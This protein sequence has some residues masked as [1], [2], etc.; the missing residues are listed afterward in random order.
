MARDLRRYNTRHDAVLSILATSVKETLPPSTNLTV[1]IGGQYKFPCYIIPT[2]LRPD[3]VWWN[4]AEKSLNLMEL[5]VCFES[6][7]EDAAQ[8][9]LSKYTELTDL[10]QQNGYET[11]LLPVQ[12]GSRGVPD[13]PSFKALAEETGMSQK[14]LTVLIKN[15]TKA[16][17]VES[18]GIWCSRNHQTY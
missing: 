13:Y 4:D 6:N 9:K 11:V 7:F 2:D 8:R 15:V 16:V 5:T 14:Q 18:Y 3:M 12:M 1:D 17:I 10:A